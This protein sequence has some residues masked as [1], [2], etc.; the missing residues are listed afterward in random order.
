[1]S[2][3]KVCHRR[4]RN[5]LEFI[6]SNH[7]DPELSLRSAAGRVRLSTY[8]L[9]RWLKHE[10]GTGFSQHLRAARVTHAS[11]LLQSTD[12]SVK[13]IAGAVGYSNTNALD[14]NFKAA[15]TTTPQEYRNRMDAYEAGAAKIETDPDGYGS[16]RP[17][18]QS[19]S[20]ARTLL[21]GQRPRD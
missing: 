10:T 1:M 17:H 21:Y 18:D 3:T 14:R 5:V 7:T 20:E 8:H 4:L 6:Q 9:S 12:L 16:A 2:A 13:E 11:E 19:V 15:F